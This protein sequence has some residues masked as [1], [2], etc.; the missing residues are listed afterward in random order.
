MAMKYG[1]PAMKSNRHGRVQEYVL[2]GKG[3]I[4]I[5]TEGMSKSRY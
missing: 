2:H 3:W 4:M 1:S 5:R